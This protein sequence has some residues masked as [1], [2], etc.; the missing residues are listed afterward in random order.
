MVVTRD[1]VAY[2]LAGEGGRRGER[3][4][5]LEGFPFLVRM[6]PMGMELTPVPMMV[7]VVIVR[8]PS[9]HFRRR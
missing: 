3:R 5:N 9:W 6:L 7:R 8:S 1:R 2:S 4:T